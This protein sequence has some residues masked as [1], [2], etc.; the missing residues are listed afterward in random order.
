MGAGPGDPF[1][2]QLRHELPRPNL[3]EQFVAD[4]IGFYAEFLGSCAPV[5][6][7]SAPSTNIYQNCLAELTAGAR[8]PRRRRSTITRSGGSFQVTTVGGAGVIKAETAKTWGWRRLLTM[9]SR[10]ADFSLAVDYLATSG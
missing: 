9:P 3:Y 7:K 10:I 6:P 8:V 1:P 2:R 4:K 5:S